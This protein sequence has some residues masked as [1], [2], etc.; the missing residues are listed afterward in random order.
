MLFIILAVSPI[1]YLLSPPFFFTVFFS[2][3]LQSRI[4]LVTFSFP[5]PEPRVFLVHREG[6]LPPHPHL[7]VSTTYSLSQVRF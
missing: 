5:S 3:F 7:F 1:L 6:F 4:F 2:F